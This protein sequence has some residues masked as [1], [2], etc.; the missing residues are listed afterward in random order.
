MIKNSWF[1]SQHQNEYFSLRLDGYPD[2]NSP[3]QGT[4]NPFE[5]FFVVGKPWQILPLQ[6]QYEIE[7]INNII[8]ED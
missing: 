7:Q 5:Y 6:I 2:L 3:G 1:H 4:C 8:W